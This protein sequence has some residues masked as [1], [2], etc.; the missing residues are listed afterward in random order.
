MKENNFFLIPYC[1]CYRI[2]LSL[3]LCLSFYYR[4]TAP[5]GYNVLITITDFQL[6]G[7]NA[8]A[9]E[10]DYDTLTLYDGPFVHEEDKIGTYCGIYI[11]DYFQ[12]GGRDLT[13]VFKSDAFLNYMGY[14]INYEFVEG[15]IPLGVKI[16][17][18]GQFIQIRP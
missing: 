10:N 14:S 8:L 5:E 3:V 18:K 1:V 2:T 13:I 4:I 7:D 9:C 17:Y 12:S 15:R 11:A 16:S 6:E